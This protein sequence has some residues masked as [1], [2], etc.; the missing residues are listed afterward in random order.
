[1]FRTVELPEDV[2]GTLYLYSM[3]GWNEPFDTV[4]DAIVGSNVAR[5]V[6]LTPDHEVLEKSPDYARAIASGLPWRHVPYGVPDFGIPDNPEAFKEVV[7]DAAAA[8]RRGENVLVHCAAGIGR[9]GTFAVAILCQLNVPLSE[10]HEIVK[11]A[12]SRAEARDQVTFLEKL[13]ST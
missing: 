9:T 11:R 10:A 4:R 5:V 3:P 7:T 8:L 6:C 12:G 1:M 2:P 13:C